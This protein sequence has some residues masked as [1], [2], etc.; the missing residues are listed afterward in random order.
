MTI[1]IIINSPL[2]VKGFSQKNNFLWQKISFLLTDSP[3]LCYNKDRNAAFVADISRKEP[4][5]ELLRESDFRK[6]LKSGPRAGYLFFGD[7]DYL[8][9]HALRNAMEE[10]APDP[11]FAVFNVLRLDGLNFT[12]QKLLDALMPM[13]MMADKKLIT[14]TGLN[15]ETMKPAEL[16]EL[17]DVLSGMESYD[18]NLVIISASADCLDPGFLPKRPSTSLKK[19]SEHLTPVHFE[20]VPPARL[21][22]WAQKHFLHNGVNASPTLCALLIDYC[23]KSMFAL[24][25]E[26]DKLSWYTRSHGLSDVTEENLR[27]VCTPASEYDT[28]AFANAIM[29]GN[30]EIA[31]AIL[32][33]Y[34]LRRMDPIIVLSD[35][36]R[37]FCAMKV[38]SS[39]TEEGVSQ[40]EIASLLNIHEFRVGLYQKSLRQISPERLKRALDA[41]MLA[42]STLKLSPLEYAPLERL[43]CSI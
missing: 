23:G 43:I 39:L 27:L 38:V 13:P 25:Q 15:F 6:E 37:V 30:R 10:I 7:E 26:I 5:M 35:A 24:A 2:F 36:V 19:L 33:D 16:D 11:T 17:C 20:R 18:Y 1:Y 12:P 3:L 32:S 29:N 31:L 28:F 14:V 41:C 40:K 22:A 34:K 4:P 8:K 42:D 21:A 9:A